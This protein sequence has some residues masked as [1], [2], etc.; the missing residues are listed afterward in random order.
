M[1]NI[2][3]YFNIGFLLII[4][5]IQININNQLKNKNIELMNYKKNYEKLII[6]LKNTINILE[7]ENKYY[8]NYPH[9]K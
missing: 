1:I 3:L 6:Q 8:R 2:I 5:C 9:S 4:T 7:N